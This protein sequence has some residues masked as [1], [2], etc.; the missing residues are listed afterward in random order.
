MQQIEEIFILKKSLLVLLIIFFCFYTKSVFSQQEDFDYL[1]P[2]NDFVLESGAECTEATPETTFVGSILLNNQSDIDSLSGVTKIVG[3]LR[4]S[5]NLPREYD[6]SAFSS[7]VELEG[8]ITAANTAITRTITNVKGGFNCLEHVS[9]NLQLPF[10]SSGAVISEFQSLISVGGELSFA[11]LNTSIDETELFSSL[12]FVGDL[13][14]FLRSV[15]GITS[16]FLSGITSVDSL[17]L[18]LSNLSDETMSGFLS[19]VQTVNTILV[20]DEIPALSGITSLRTLTIRNADIL[21]SAFVSLRSVTGALTI[22]P[23]FVRNVSGLNTLNSVGGSFRMIGSTSLASITG[24]QNLRSIGQDLVLRNLSLPTTIDA[25]NS[26]VSVGGNL[27]IDATN[28]VPR[29]TGI[30]GFSSLEL[31]SGDLIIEGFNDLLSITGFDSLAIVVGDMKISSNDELL[32]IPGLPSLESISGDLM[33]D[34]NPSLRSISGLSSLTRDG[35]TGLTLIN[36]NRLLDC[37]NPV[38]NFAPI[39][40]NNPAE[41]SFGN[42]VNCD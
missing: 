41:I 14:I 35:I 28:N 38:P 10:D 6:I 32:D 13:D 19:S 1:I 16:A 11:F 42:R 3:D 40:S 2:I 18:N 22:N 20:V 9:G 17:D 36:N 26:L 21:D 27:I 34:S 15:S 31:V 8:N 30:A 7:L 23:N 4:F 29:T 12:K 33:I 39:L 25:F 37:T 5:N 24:F